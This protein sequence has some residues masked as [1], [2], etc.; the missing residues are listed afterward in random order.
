MDPILGPIDVLHF[1]YSP[2]IGTERVVPVGTDQDWDSLRVYDIGACSLH[3]PWG[4]L[5]ALL[6]SGVVRQLQ[7]N[8]NVGGPVATGPTGSGVPLNVGPILDYDDGETA[9]ELRYDAFITA[10]SSF[11]CQDVIIDFETRYRT[12]SVEVTTRP[13]RCGG[14]ILLPSPQVDITL[15]SLEARAEV[16]DFCIVEDMV[17]NGLIDS[18]ENGL[19]SAFAGVMRGLSEVDS[20]ILGLDTV[21]CACDAECQTPESPRGACS[22]PEG[23][24]T[25]TCRFAAEID[26]VM[27]MPEGV[28]FVYSESLA[29]DPQGTVLL[30]ANFEEALLTNLGP[31]LLLRLL[32][33]QYGCGAARAPFVAPGAQ[34]NRRDVRAVF[35][36]PSL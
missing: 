4:V 5:Q 18:L 24:Q 27:L 23:A 31:P 25:G 1:P 8:G 3:I 29:S 22:V 33:V 13:E 30:N 36:A 17:E 35:D 26:R 32:G 14:E 15:T 34:P 28:T 9:D 6:N 20:E 21:P 11:G 2:S 7:M 12:G 16:R 19:P 10:G